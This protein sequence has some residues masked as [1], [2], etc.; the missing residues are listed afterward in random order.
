MTIAEYRFQNRKYPAGGF[1]LIRPRESAIIIIVGGENMAKRISCKIIKSVP[2]NV[3]DN[4]SAFRVT[5][6]ASCSKRR[7][8]TSIYTS[9]MVTTKTCIDDKSTA[10]ILDC[11]A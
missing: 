6:D 10:Q 5:V 9:R 3:T 1:F 4:R 2:L 7:I 8:G 11:R